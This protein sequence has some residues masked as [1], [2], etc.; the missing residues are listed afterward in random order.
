[1]LDVVNHIYIIAVAPTIISRILQVVAYLMVINSIVLFLYGIDK[2]SAQH[3]GLRISENTFH[4]LTIMGG[5]L[6]AFLGQRLF[7]HKIL[8]RSFQDAFRLIVAIQL[9]ALFVGIF[10][11]AIA[12]QPGLPV[13]EKIFEAPV[14]STPSTKLLYLA[15]LLSAQTE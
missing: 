8:K 9:L 13:P 15:P 10:F 5:T 2:K 7:R 12:H 14:I 3:N 4:I 1:M 11:V 6:G